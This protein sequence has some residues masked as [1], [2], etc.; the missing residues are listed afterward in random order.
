M[1]LDSTSHLTTSRDSC[2]ATRETQAAVSEYPLLKGSLYHDRRTCSLQWLPSSSSSHQQE[3]SEKH[4]LWREGGRETAGVSYRIAKYGHC[5]N[6]TV[7]T[8][9]VP[10]R[11]SR[12]S[13]MVL[14]LP[15]LKLNPISTHRDSESSETTLS[16]GKLMRGGG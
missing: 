12:V 5:C 10:S 2:C 4:Y 16:L 9:S 8:Q 15:I 14:M 6:E 11:C 13:R 1:S 7:C 3:D